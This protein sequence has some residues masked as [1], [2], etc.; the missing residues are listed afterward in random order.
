MKARYPGA[1]AVLRQNK[2]FLDGRIFSW[3]EEGLCEESVFN[4][5][6]AGDFVKQVRAEIR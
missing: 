2:L 1:M 4:I 5:P 6:L 3:R